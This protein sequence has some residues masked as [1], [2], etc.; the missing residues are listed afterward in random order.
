MKKLLLALSLVVATQANAQKSWE[1]KKPVLCASI[2][3]VAAMI[4]NNQ[5]KLLWRSVDADSGNIITV[6]INTKK[7]SWTIIESGKE[8]AC[9]LATGEEF[10]LT[11][12]D[13]KNSQSKPYL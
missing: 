12:P 6:F 10:Q 5:E 2:K 1:L 7:M 4:S 11:M 13:G 8:N 3:D 9:I